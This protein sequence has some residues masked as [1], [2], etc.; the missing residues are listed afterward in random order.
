MLL[1]GCVA[2]G[3]PTEKELSLI[4]TGQRPIVLLRI[5]GE[6]DGK[7]YEPF[8]HILGSCLG[9]Y[10]IK[11]GIGD[12][13]TGGQLRFINRVRCLT[14]ETRQKGWTYFLLE[15][16]IYYLGVGTTYFPP[17][18]RIDVPEDVSLIYVGTV[19]L[20]DKGVYIVR[21]EEDL[22]QRIFNEQFP[23]V[24]M[25]RTVLMKRMH[26]DTVILRTPPHREPQ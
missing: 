8:K 12:F 22:A 18:W 20:R 2:T 14:G 4:Q 15:P 24:G 5:T 1:T 7:P 26:S 13:E 11:L 25:F 6:R 17:I 23:S 10:N 3:L 16:G 21:N 19:H 9:S